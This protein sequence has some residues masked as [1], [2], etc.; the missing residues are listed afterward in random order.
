MKNEPEQND[1]V[2]DQCLKSWR[3]TVSLP[4]G[5]QEQVWRRIEQAETSREMP[6]VPAFQN[7]VNAFLAHRAWVA[8]YLALALVIGLALGFRQAREETN[9]LSANLGQRYVQ[10][11]DPYLKM[12][13]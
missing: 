7:L 2:L 8:S 13:P 4:P 1:P 11:L 9:S 6:L 12:R 3:V 5:F 10:S